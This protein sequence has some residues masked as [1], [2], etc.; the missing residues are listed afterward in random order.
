[1]TIYYL[2]D[3]P[4]YLQHGRIDL[5]T[6]LFR[7]F[8]I[9]LKFQ[10]VPDSNK[11]DHPTLMGK[12]FSIPYRKNRFY[13][14]IGKNSFPTTHF[15]TGNEQYVTPCQFFPATQPSNNDISLVDPLPGENIQQS[16][17]GVF[18]HD[19]ELEGFLVS[20]ECR[21]RPFDKFGE[22]IQVGSLELILAR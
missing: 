22:I 11:I 20:R 2:L 7:Y 16:A 14:H 3:N 15:G 13:H 8:S 9:D 17:K 4:T 1:M 21:C 18:T 10:F 12:T 5:Q 19:T 6:G